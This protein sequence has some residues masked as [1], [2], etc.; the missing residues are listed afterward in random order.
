M[1]EATGQVL[2]TSEPSFAV[3]HVR[4]ILLTSASVRALSLAELAARGITLSAENFQAFNFADGFAFRDEIVEI[5][6]PIVYSGFGTVKALDKPIVQLDGLPPDVAHEVERWQPPHIVPF[7]LEREE[8]QGLRAE[9][10]EDEELGAQEVARLQRPFDRAA[11][12]ERRPARP[13]RGVPFVD[14]AYGGTRSVSCPCGARNPPEQRAAGASWPCRS[15]RVASEP[16]Q[17]A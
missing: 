16:A 11:D 6:L 5:E 4:E 2:G 7:R 8:R 17:R 3:L 10:E 12:V 1:D 15:A 14:I 13:F 9:S